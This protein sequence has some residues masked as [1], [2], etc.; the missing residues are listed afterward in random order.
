MSV[1]NGVDNESVHESDLNDQSLVP[2]SDIVN[3]YNKRGL[4]NNNHYDDR[5]SH[6]L[7]SAK[8][9]R[10]NDSDDISSLSSSS[11]ELNGTSDDDQFL[12]RAL[13]GNQ[14][15]NA[16]FDSVN[17]MPSPNSDDDDSDI[18]FTTDSEEEE[19]DIHR[20]VEQHDKNQKL[21]RKKKRESRTFCVVKD[22]FKVNDKII[23]IGAV[24]KIES[25]D[26]NADAEELN[27]DDEKDINEDTLYRLVMAIPYDTVE[28]D[29]YSLDVK[30]VFSFGM[31]CVW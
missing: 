20:D 11:S 6:R 28:L 30:K 9:V 19:I 10:H 1:E 25:M 21:L 5:T 18:S 17:E 31:Y 8:R 12:S 29:L 24:A 16:N 22:E 14:M 15:D 23:K 3:G 2:T 26:E 27:E 7:K 4:N 13:H